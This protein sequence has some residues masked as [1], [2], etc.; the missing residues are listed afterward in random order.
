MTIPLSLYEQMHANWFEP[1][2]RLAIIFGMSTFDACYKKLPDGT[3]RQAFDNLDSTSEDCKR[4]IDCLEK[5][6]IE[7]K[8]VYDFSHNPTSRDVEYALSQI[9]AKLRAGK[10]QRP[11]VRYLVIFLFAG[12]GLQLDGQ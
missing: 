5:F 7:T 6:Q 12:H 8:N 3:Y 11:M 10:K 2:H 9:S 1:D 4:L